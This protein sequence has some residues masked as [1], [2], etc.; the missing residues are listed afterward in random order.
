MWFQKAAQGR[1]AD[2]Q[3]R[4]A[5]AYEYGHFDLAIDLKEALDW[6][7]TAAKVATTTR[8]GDSAKPSKKATSAWRL[9]RR[10]R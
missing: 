1:D 2:A 6:Y 3:L 8:N 7:Q 5:E 9:T 10:R 4:L